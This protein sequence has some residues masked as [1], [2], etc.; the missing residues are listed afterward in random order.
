MDGFVGPVKI[1][2]RDFDPSIHSTT[3][4][5]VE[6]VGIVSSGESNEEETYEEET[7]ADA[8]MLIERKKPGRKA[9]IR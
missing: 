5:N 2:V 4:P 1:A 6:A 3:D 7:E 8:G 9:K